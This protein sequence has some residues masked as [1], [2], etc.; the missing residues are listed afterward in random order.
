MTNKPIKL[1]LLVAIGLFLAACGLASDDVPSLG[2]TPTAVVE[3]ETLDD[4]AAIDGIRGV[5]A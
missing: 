1:I 3:E 4:E 5:H 2:A